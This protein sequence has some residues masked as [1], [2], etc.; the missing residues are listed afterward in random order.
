MERNDASVD[1][2]ATSS[3]TDANE[4]SGSGS[5]PQSASFDFEGNAPSADQSTG[6]RDRAKNVIGSA[7][8]KLADVGSTVRERANTAKDKLAD[9]L[10][11][12]AGRLR[13]RSQTGEPTLAGATAD[14]ST[15]IPADSR[16]AQV[17]DK[18]AGGM[19]VTAEWLRDADLDS[20]KTGLENQ[21][22]EHPGRTLL[23]AAGLGYLIARAFRSTQ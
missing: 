8:D 10:E 9:A 20:I 12:G 16:I 22:K 7:G 17:S 2:G 4:F 11:S 6:I 15:A 14:G 18:V 3:Q 23:I 13:D 19:E 21:V 5:T 1:G